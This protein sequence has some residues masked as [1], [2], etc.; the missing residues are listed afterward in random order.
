MARA[1]LFRVAMRHASA[2]LLL[3]ITVLLFVPARA[4]AQ[5]NMPPDGAPIKT[6]QVSGLDL[7][8][9]SP[10]LQADI[11]K[12][13]GNPLNRQQLRD[14]AA[15][16]EAEQP[17]FVAAVRVT[18]DPDGGARVFFVAARMRDA[19][20]QGDVNAKYVVEDVR[21]YG[22]SESRITAEMRADQ[23]ALEGKPMDADLAERLQ[24]R[25]QASFEKYSVERRTS[26]GKQPGQIRLIFRLERKEE[27]F[28]LRFEKTDDNLVY[29]SDQGWGAILPLTMSSN[30]FM[31]Q[32]HFAFSS[33]NE[34]VEEY[35][36]G[37]VR[38]DTRKLGTD[39]LGLFFDWSTFE[40]TW[41]KET[42]AAIVGSTTLTALYRSRRTVTPLLKFAI[43]P[44][45][46]VA[47]GVSIVELDDLDESSSG[48]RMANAAVWSVR[49]DQ[50][51]KL[52]PKVLH[53]LE[54]SF[55]TRVGTE[56][57]ESDL[58]YKRHLGEATYLFEQRRHSL[59]LS[60]MAGGTTGDAPLFERFTLGDAATLRGWSKYEIA[61]LG[62]DRVFHASAEYR[63]R[64][65]AV[66]LDS[67]S[68]WNK[69]TERKLRFST[70]FGYAPGPVFMMLGFPLNTSD[71]R[72]VFMM[73]LRFSTP[74]PS[75]PKD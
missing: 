54:A 38:F 53:D 16:L 7:S 14:L 8:R 74:R 50:R 21:I 35:S 27:S 15:R 65:L 45:L 57:L 9:L 73:G 75:F 41:R 56:S 51:W 23:K 44:H 46:A 32:P 52:A 4:R 12:L 71:S 62:G 66:F 17:R 36:G 61:P 33:A 25:L 10:G 49:F 55:T 22:V 13:A 2:S 64:G 40:Q 63:Y 39:R 29:H 34:L 67:G 68:V 28:W 43:T 24:A 31:V 30:E 72:A 42:L 69:G 47:G 5:E 59:L 70:G 19:D 3:C 20:H 18:A 11:G 48:S 58:V 6:A 1:L 60:G 26:R 37:G